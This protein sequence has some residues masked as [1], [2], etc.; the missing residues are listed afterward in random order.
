MQSVFTFRTLLLAA[1]A[2]AAL[3]S[4]ALAQDSIPAPSPDSSTQSPVDPAAPFVVAV[5]QVLVTARRRE[6][7][8]QDVPVALSVIG[9]QQI[10]ATGSY[11]VAQLTQLTP[12]VQFFSSN[13]RNTA[14]TIRGLGTSFG[15][16]NDG[17][18][19]GVGLYIDQV[20][21]SRPAAATFDLIDID[22]VEVLRGPQGTLFG[23]N[24]TAGAINVS[25][26]Q[27]TFER[28]VQAE[29]SA[30]NYGFYQ[31]KATI[32]G[33]LAG[34]VLAGRLSVSGTLRDGMIQNVTTGKDV[35]NQN[36]F[37]TRA[38]LLY[39]PNESF[40]LRIAAD[41]NRQ[42]TPCCAQSFVRIGTTLKPAAQQFPALAAA[43]G[44]A[45]ASLDPFDRKVDTNSPSKANQVI[46]GISAIADWELAE[47]A[48]YQESSG[49]RREARGNNAAATRLG[50]RRLR[51]RHPSLEKTYGT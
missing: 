41:Y 36:D 15:L 46:G 4:S 51:Q 16:T 31:G 45:P 7:N 37:G 50:A 38:Q 25:I 18:E 43:A 3:T 42:Q 26:Q 49:Q 30:G 12:S 21:M 24:T 29:V 47:S 33:P 14:I 17:L 48:E 40:S 19:P 44:Y 10:E 32:S 35:N 23:K 6:E 8:A 9:I 39:R 5:E 28:L 20:Y 22:R 11:N 34:N 1:S 13:P 2:A 27:P